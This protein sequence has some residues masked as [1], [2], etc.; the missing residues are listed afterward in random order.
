[1][2]QV[3]LSERTSSPDKIAFL[4]DGSRPKTSPWI[5]VYHELFTVIILSIFPTLNLQET[6]LSRTISGRV[7]EDICRE[8]Q[9]MWKSAC[10]RI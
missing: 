9:V 5:A 10:F 7:W 4:I 1:M 6:T 8:I 2:V 3:G